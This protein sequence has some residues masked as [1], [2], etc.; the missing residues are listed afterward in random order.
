MDLLFPKFCIVCK[1]WGKYVCDNC[2]KEIEVMPDYICPVCNN[3]ATPDLI[4]N[5]CKRETQI[6]GVVSY[7]KYNKTAKKI[8]KAIKY[9][10][11]YDIYNEI[12]N[13]I[14]ISEVFSSFSDIYKNCYLQPIPL[15]SN[16]LKKRGFNQAEELAKIF[17]KKFQFPVIDS[18][19]RVK[20]TKPQ[21]QIHH[22]KHRQENIKGAFNIIKTDFIKGNII[23]LVDDVYTSGST[24]Y[25]AAKILKN[26]GAD[27]VFVW[28]L[29]R[30]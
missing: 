6:S 8:V 28:S 5:Y 13:I 24:C 17:S 3:P 23:I 9:Q 20:D 21:A 19:I 2:R 18:L 25:E 22:K 16:R 27:A 30:D 12:S 4:H 1:K 14:S 7:M 10:L 26:A 11:I 29:A 15:H